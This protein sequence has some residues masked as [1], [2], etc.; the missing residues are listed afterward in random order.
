MLFAKSGWFAG[1]EDM[2]L[3]FEQGLVVDLKGGGSYGADLKEKLGIGKQ[4]KEV[5]SRR[6][7]AELG[8][9]TNPFARFSLERRLEAEKIRGTGHVAIGDNST[10]GGNV[11]ADLH[12]DFI[13]P[14]V[15]ILLD[16]KYIIREGK[17]QV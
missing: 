6:N 13:I 7:L 9:G 11:S 1:E 14:K 5:S 12:L 15:S 2:T 16:G 3:T 4:G 10:I 8:S 17:I